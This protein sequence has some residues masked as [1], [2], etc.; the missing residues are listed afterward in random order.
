MSPPRQYLVTTRFIPA[1]RA[2]GPSIFLVFLRRKKRGLHR[3]C[4][5][6]PFWQVLLGQAKEF[7]GKIDNWVPKIACS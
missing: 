2:C 6:T 1:G 4:L 7:W 5:K 3:P